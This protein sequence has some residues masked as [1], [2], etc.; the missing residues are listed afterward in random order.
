M[1]FQDDYIFEN[2]EFAPINKRALII[3]KPKSNG[4]ID[5]NIYVD[6]LTPSGKKL[7][8]K[9]EKT[10][11]KLYTIGF[12]PNEIGDHEIRFYHD[13]EKKLIMT[14][15]NCQVYDISK[16]RVSDLPLAVT[17]QPCKFTSKI[18]FFFFFFKRKFRIFLSLN[19]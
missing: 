5:P 10:S 7:K 14:K 16:I 19:I 6:I 15:L 11:T 17:H 13:E 8:S 1:Y 18:N 2:Y 3:I 4:I 12:V 9:I